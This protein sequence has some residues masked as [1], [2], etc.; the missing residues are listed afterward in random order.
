MKLN[1]IYHIICAFLMT[2]FAILAFTIKDEV[3]SQLF[4]CLSTISGV[5]ILKLMS[6]Q[7]LNKW[8]ILK[9]LK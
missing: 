3:I 5:L 8:K 2:S 4:A 7:N 6:T 9:H 1:D